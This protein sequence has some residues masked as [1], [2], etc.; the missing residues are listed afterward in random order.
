MVVLCPRRDLNFGRPAAV[1]EFLQERVH[2]IELRVA[3][4]DPGAPPLLRAL[5][6][7]VQPDAQVPASTRA[8]RAAVRGSAQEKPLLD[9]IAAI[10]IARFSGRPLPELCAMGGI[11]LEDLTQSAAY[12]EIYGHGRLEGRQQ[13]IQQGRQQGECEMALRQLRRRCGALSSIQQDRIRALPLPQL[14][15]LSEALLDF[16]GLADLQAWLDR[17]G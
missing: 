6:L 13:G 3:A 17:A 15:A 12:R 9:V 8:I 2:W 4:A 10:V 5:A 7:L 14:E 16:Q 11:T 1:A